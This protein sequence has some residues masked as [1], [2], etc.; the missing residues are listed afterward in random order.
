MQA[1]GS[2]TACIMV[3]GTIHPADIAGMYVSCIL[4]CMGSGPSMSQLDARPLLML[5]HEES[6][7]TRAMLHVSLPVCLCMYVYIRM[8]KRLCLSVCVC[9]CVCEQV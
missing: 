4:V 3:R 7:G 8:C 9:V 1:P 6:T 5:D 2:W